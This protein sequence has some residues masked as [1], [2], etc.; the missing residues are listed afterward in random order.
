MERITQGFVD[1]QIENT[2]NALHAAGILRPEDH[3]AVR[4]SGGTKF[5]LRLDIM[6]PEGHLGTLRTSATLRTISEDLD[7]LRSL[8]HYADRLTASD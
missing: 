6:C 2:N 3:I 1:R 5:P 8:G 7:L 4:D